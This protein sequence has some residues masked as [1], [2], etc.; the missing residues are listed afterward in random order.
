VRWQELFDDL[1]AQF[2]A[3]AA[4]ELAAEISDRTRRETALIRLVDRLRPSI[5]QLISLRLTGL[6]AIEGRLTA[7]GPDWLLLDEIA[8]REVVVNMPAVLSIAG[9][10]AQS[11]AGDVT[12]NVAARLTLSY[13]LRG[14]ARDRSPVI[15]C[16]TDGSTSAGT[17]D[18]VGADFVEIAEHPPG[19][20][21]RRDSVRAVRTVPFGSLS[22]LRRA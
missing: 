4:A 16:Y 20:A 12:P 22:S 13:A 14:L 17:L 7:V 15:A 21:R 18:R 10:S 6:G 19:E 1:E 3:A 2:D 8:G 5:G 11:S 9:L